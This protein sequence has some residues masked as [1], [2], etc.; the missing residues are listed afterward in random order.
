MT[1][2]CD[3]VL[4][5]NHNTVCCGLKCLAKASLVP[6]QALNMTIVLCHRLTVDCDY[7]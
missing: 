1:S 4:C 2:V 5:S 6:M 3:D 7:I